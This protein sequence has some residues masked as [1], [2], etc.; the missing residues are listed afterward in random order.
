MDYPLNNASEI[1][2]VVYQQQGDHTY[3]QPYAKITLLDQNDKEVAN[4]QAAYD[5][6]Y[7]FTDLRPG[8]YRAVVD[9]QFKDRKALKN[10]QQVKVN[11]SPKG[12]VLL[13]VDFTLK[14]L[15]QVS[16]TIVNA[17]SFSSLM[18]LKTYLRLIS[19][20]LTLNQQEV[21]YIHDQQQNKYILALG[22][23]EHAQPEFAGICQSLITQG[24][25]CELEQ[26]TILH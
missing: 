6:Y 23:A 12:D 7:L 14:S 24:L 13:G 3:V 25:K 15:E 2:G 20:R 9:E 10:T 18:M 4:T 26:R 8:Q 22:Y 5:G 1:E 19:P 11:L 21:F 17:G 16:G